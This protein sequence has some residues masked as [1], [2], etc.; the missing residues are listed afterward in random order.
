MSRARDLSNLANQNALSVDSSSFDV[1]VS[2][3]SPDSDL[4]VGGAIKMDGPSGVITATSFSGDGSAL[5]G[6]AATDTIAAAS[7]TVSGISTLTGVVKGLSDLR[8]TGNLNAGIVTVT[9]IT[10]DGSGL[11]GVANTDVVHTREITASGVSTFTGYVSTGS[12][13][14]AAGSI[15]FPDNKGINF[16]NAAEGDLQIYHDGSH[17]IIEESGTGGLK[18]VSNSSFQLRDTNK[19]T[20]DYCINAN[21]NGDVSLYSN[22]TKRIE[23]T[24]TGAVITGIATASSVEITNGTAFVDKHSV[25]I[26]TTTTAGRNAGLGT[27]SGTIAY[28]ETLAQVCYYAGDSVGWIGISST[29]NEPQFSATGGTKSV[30]PTHTIHAFTSTGPA[31]FV[32]TGNTPKS[33]SVF[34]VGGGGGGA[35][36]STNGGYGGGGGGGGGIAYHPAL[37]IGTGTYNVVV[38]TGGAGG[39]NNTTGGNAGDGVDS[40]FDP[41]GVGPFPFVANGGGAGM[42]NDTAGKAGGSGG[43]GGTSPTGNGAGGSATGNSVPTGGST[44]GNAGGDSITSA[45]AFWG[46]GGGGAGAVGGP[47]GSPPAW[48]RASGPYAQGGDGIGSPTIPWLPTS[49]G[50]SSYFAGG[51]GGGGWSDSGPGSDP[52]AV[53]GGNGGGADSRHGIPVG[54][55]T[56]ATANTGGGGAGGNGTPGKNG[57]AGG[58][59]IVLIRYAN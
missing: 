52:G 54:T 14:G 9:S 39:T 48:P 6:V 22:G 55:L 23:T 37:T 51:G 46:G 44:Y 35:M 47:G 18:L 56:N 41:T 15:Y 13:V 57:T 20:G 36:G 38:G 32:V 2:S 26:G 58:S 24:N 21:I 59:G 19:D 34:V 50:E 42:N 16:G 1:G 43:G 53:P 31:T 49:H 27:A 30:G 11:T 7:L 8:V 3:T 45:D 40:T 5:I 25:G 17:S 12:T 29:Q 10:G 4:N 28:N 33:M